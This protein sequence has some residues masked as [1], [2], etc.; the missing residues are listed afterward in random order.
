[1]HSQTTLQKPDAQLLAQANVSP[2][3]RHGQTPA[4]KPAPGAKKYRKS[5]DKYDV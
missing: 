5:S 1:M 2:S 3:R 4:S